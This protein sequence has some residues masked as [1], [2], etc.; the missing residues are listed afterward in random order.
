VFWF[1]SGAIAGL[2]V[3]LNVVLSLPAIAQVTLDGSLGAGGALTGPDYVVPQAAGQTAGG[4][5]LFHSFGQFNI[6]PGQSVT[7]QS[8]PAI[9]NILARVTGGQ[10]T[11]EGLIATQSRTANLFLDRGRD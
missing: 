5:N 8:D 3:S 9:R 4:V 7:F 10:S 1:Y 2:T 11:I 6:N